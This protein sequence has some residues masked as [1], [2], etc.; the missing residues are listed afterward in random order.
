MSAFQLI[1]ELGG[2]AERRGKLSTLWLI[3]LAFESQLLAASHFCVLCGAVFFSF[4]PR[5]K[6]GLKNDASKLIL[7]STECNNIFNDV[8]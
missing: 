6:L 7:G 3:F 4:F 8:V 2:E 5:V 1:F